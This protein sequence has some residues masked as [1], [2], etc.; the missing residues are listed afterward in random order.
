MIIDS[1]FTVSSQAAKT[2]MYNPG[3]EKHVSKDQDEGHNR[4]KLKFLKCP[5]LG[6]YREKTVEGV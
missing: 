2:Q 6:T 4:N 3:L 5:A 1:L